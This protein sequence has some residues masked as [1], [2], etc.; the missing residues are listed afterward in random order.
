[1]KRPKSKATAQD[2]D[3]YLARDLK[4]IGMHCAGKFSRGCTLGPGEN[5]AEVA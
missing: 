2:Q 4:N 1:M 5:T 3:T